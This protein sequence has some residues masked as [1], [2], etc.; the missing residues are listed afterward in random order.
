MLFYIADIKYV[1]NVDEMARNNFIGDVLTAF[2][3]RNV[4]TKRYFRYEIT[5]VLTYLKDI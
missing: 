4:P 3:K 2:H 1:V 5:P